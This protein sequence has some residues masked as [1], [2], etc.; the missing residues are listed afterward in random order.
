MLAAGPAA[1]GCTVGAGADNHEP[2]AVEP[3]RGLHEIVDALV[4]AWRAEKHHDARVAHAEAR[5]C[6]G[7]VEALRRPGV[8]IAHVGHEHAAE[9]LG[10]KARG[11][12]QRVRAGDESLGEP[13]PRQAVRI[14]D[15]E[16]SADPPPDAAPIEE[17]ELPVVDVEDQRAAPLAPREQSHA[18]AGRPRLGREEHVAIGETRQCGQLPRQAWPASAR[19]GAV[20]DGAVARG[21]PDVGAEAR[22]HHLH[23][24]A[25]REQA[26]EEIG[27][28]GRVVG[29]VEREDGDLHATRRA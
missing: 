13:G 24:V 26:R 11:H 28:A 6:G 16:Q 19:L 7:A 22:A 14:G 12:G 3:R 23:F 10:E 17:A 8:G 20:A 2:R 21:T 27:A 9:A 4:R 29:K 5:A 1:R 15:V 18:E 25:R